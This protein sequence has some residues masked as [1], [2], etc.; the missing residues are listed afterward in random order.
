[1]CGENILQAIPASYRKKKAKRL[2]NE[3]EKREDA[4]VE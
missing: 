4:R 2:M 1:M 3:N